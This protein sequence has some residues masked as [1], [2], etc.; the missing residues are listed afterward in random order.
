VTHALL[1]A[2]LLSS[3]PDVGDVPQDPHFGP[4]AHFA[5]GIEF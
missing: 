2:A 4:A 1:C 3:T 5:F